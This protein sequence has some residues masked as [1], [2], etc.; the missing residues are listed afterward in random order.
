[1]RFLRTRWPKLVIGL[2]SVVLTAG[3]VNTGATVPSGVRSGER[4]IWVPEEI[5]R[6]K[7]SLADE[8]GDPAEVA[9][10]AQIVHSESRALRIDPLYVLAIMKVESGFHADAVGP[11]GAVGL[12]QVQP[13]TARSVMRASAAPAGAVRSVRLHDPRTNVALGLRYLRQLESQFSDRQTV[14]AAYNMGPT[15]VRR[16]LAERKPLSRAYADRVLSVYR[17]LRSGG[18]G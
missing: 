6:L 10:L 13:D 7:R 11:R 16:S 5:E 15:R 9:E 1:M 12:L 18:K 14:L 4:V 2:T 17:A 8:I 3:A